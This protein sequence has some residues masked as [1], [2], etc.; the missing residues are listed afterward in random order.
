MDKKLY[1]QYYLA[2][3]THNINYLCKIEYSIVLNIWYFCY[4]IFY[5]SMYYYGNI[6]FPFSI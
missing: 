3:K 1:D 4:I 2:V 5:Y 6:S